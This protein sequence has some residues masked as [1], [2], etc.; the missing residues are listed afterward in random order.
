MS[1]IFG[2]KKMCAENKSEKRQ[3]I[4][5]HFRDQRHVYTF[6]FY[7][8]L[9]EMKRK[10]KYRKWEQKKK[11]ILKIYYE[12]DDDVGEMVHIR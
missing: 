2:K 8:S 6:H 9:L 1:H 3:T 12:L 10:M 7:L 5:S 4:K 11:K